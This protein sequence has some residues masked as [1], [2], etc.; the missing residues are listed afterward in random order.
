ML[1]IFIFIRINYKTVR[2]NSFSCLFFFC[3]CLIYSWS[4]F[5]QLRYS[6]PFEPVC[7]AV[8]CI[9]VYIILVHFNGHINLPKYDCIGFY[10]FFFVTPIWFYWFF[11]I[12]S[13]WKIDTTSTFGNYFYSQNIIIHNL[14][15]TIFTSMKIFKI[16]SSFKYFFLCMLLFIY[17]L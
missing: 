3:N 16:S 11:D 12:F 4:K 2:K 6:R 13:N 8:F 10:W 14:I 9:I 5:R 7:R 17:C 1:F 15:H